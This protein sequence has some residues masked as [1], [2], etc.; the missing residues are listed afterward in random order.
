M[1]VVVFLLIM[2]FIGFTNNV[3]AITM[4]VVSIDW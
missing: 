4:A 1:V 2:S 3:V